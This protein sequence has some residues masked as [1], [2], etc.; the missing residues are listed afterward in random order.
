VN[1]L[2]YLDCR[3]ICQNNIKN[4]FQ[5]YDEH[6]DWILVGEDRVLWPMLM[7]KVVHLEVLQESAEGP[8]HL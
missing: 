3:R 2:K 6:V 5:K 8:L 4:I 7:N 1:E